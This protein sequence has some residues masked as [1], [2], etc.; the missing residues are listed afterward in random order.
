MDILC[1]PLSAMMSI[2]SRTDCDGKRLKIKRASKK[3]RSVVIVKNLK[4]PTD[5]ITKSLRWGEKVSK[6]MY[7]KTKRWIVF[8]LFSQET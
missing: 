3:E 8:P 7:T 2:N 6:A 1:N 4:Q 5:T